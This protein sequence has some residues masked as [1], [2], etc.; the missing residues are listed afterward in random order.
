MIRDMISNAAELRQ[1]IA[2][3]PDMMADLTAV[4]DLGLPQG[5]IAA[6]YIRNFVW[7][8]LHGY[9]DRTPL[10]DV[11]VLYY[12]PDCLEE[13]AEKAYD[14]LLRR[15]NPGR[16]WSAKNQARMHLKNGDDPYGSVEEAMCFW[17]ET[18][19]AIG[20]RINE[21]GEVGLVTPFG[22][23]DLVGLMVRQSPFFRDRQIFADRIRQKE[24]L[25]IWPKLTVV[26]E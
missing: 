21:N 1:A 14:E 20:A 13:E 16:N 26:P 11:D 17:P 25:R 3:Q 24:W 12:D 4:A 6:G 18:A 8:M 9:K 7:D 22:L 2:D 5:C 19:T 10:Q 23:E 15:R